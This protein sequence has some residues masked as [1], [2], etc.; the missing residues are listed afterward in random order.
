M[1]LLLIAFTN[2]TTKGNNMTSMGEDY[3]KQQERARRIG[4]AMNLAHLRALAEAATPGPWEETGGARRDDVCMF[5]A[6]KD[7]GFFFYIHGQNGKNGT[8]NQA[9]D[10]ALIVA[11]RQ[12][13]PALLRI[14]EAAERRSSWYR[15][16]GE[17]ASVEEAL[18][19][20]LDFDIEMEEALSDFRADPKVTGVGK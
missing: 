3:P 6:R 10:A 19:K 1:S 7:G 5:P 11:M 9:A 18:D 13:L 8:T 2:H 16:H 15:E 4:A 12:S 14:A 17:G 20:D